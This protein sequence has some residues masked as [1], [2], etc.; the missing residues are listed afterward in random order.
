MPTVEKRNP[1]LVLVLSFVTLG[2]YGL[3]WVVKTKGELNS[4]GAKIP[5]AWILLGT[6]IPVVGWLVWFY[7]AYK[8]AG[9]YTMYVKKGDSPIL[10]TVLLGFLL[11]FA[12]YFV[13]K[14][15]NRFAK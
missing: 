5:T 6:L 3:Y 7:W 12:A 11:P 14:E 8:Y 15:L 9:A 10:W 4:F 1:L 2:I 13:Q